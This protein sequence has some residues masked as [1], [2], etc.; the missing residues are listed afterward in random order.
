M[1]EAPAHFLEEG[2]TEWA[3]MSTTSSLAVAVKY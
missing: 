3:P 1:A 2:G